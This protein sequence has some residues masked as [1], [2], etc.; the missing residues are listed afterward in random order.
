FS[1]F[2]QRSTNFSGEDKFRA[3]DDSTLDLYS[4]VQEIDI[5]LDTI[6]V[7]AAFKAGEN[8]SVGF[9][10]RYSTL[11]ARAAQQNEVEWGADIEQG[12]LP[13][14]APLSA[15]EALGILD[16]RIQ[17]EV[18]DDTDDDITF[19]VGILWKPHRKWTIGLVYKDGGAFG[20]NG[21]AFDFGCVDR[22]PDPGERCQPNMP[23]AVIQTFRV[24]DL[25]GLGIA[26]RATDTF[27]VALDVVS[28]DYSVLSIG[29]GDIPDLSPQVRDNF[30]PIERETEIHFGLEKI[31]FLGSQQ[32]PWTVRAGVYTDRDHDGI[33]P[34]DS[35]DTFYTF[36][37]GTVIAEQFQIDV[38]AKSSDRTDAGVLSMVYRF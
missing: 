15:V 24:P 8:L 29:P 14:G 11:D 28:I 2:Y 37:F 1:V 22:T 18:Y 31:F 10:V 35:E 9:S 27:K 23:E 13:I 7:S 4:T 17:S 32:M 21:D 5:Q 20:I 25:L 34:I 6:G 30:V 19:N 26:W 12:T 16:Q 36:G 38:A 33:E 3:Y